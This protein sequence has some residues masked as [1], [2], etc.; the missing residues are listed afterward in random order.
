MVLAQKEN[1][2]RLA[3]AAICFAISLVSLTAAP[4]D[5]V[6]LRNWKVNF[7]SVHARAGSR[8]VP[9]VN[10]APSPL[11]FVAVTPCRLVDTRN[12][13]GPFGGPIFAAGETRSYVLPA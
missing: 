4:K 6:P 9:A 5:P 8:F 2:R 12:A 13:S 3:I 10:S 7:D 1:M 11:H